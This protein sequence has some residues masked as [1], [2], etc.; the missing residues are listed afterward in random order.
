MPVSL[1]MS[2]V[3]PILLIHSIGTTSTVVPIVASTPKETPTMM[4]TS[5]IR[6]Q[7]DLRIHDIMHQLSG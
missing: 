4:T 7:I 2:L 6:E 3:E 5:S 1:M